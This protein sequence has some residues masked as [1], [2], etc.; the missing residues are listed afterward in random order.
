VTDEYTADVRGAYSA[1]AAAWAAGP[2]AHYRR[3][4]TALVAPAGDALR[5]AAVLD[6]G[7]GTGVVAD[8]AVA[9]GAS[10]VIGVDA[11]VAMLRHDAHRRPVAVASDTLALPFAGGSFDVA[12]AGCVLNHLFEPAAGVAEMIRV[13]RPGGKVLAS[14]FGD[15]AEHPAKAA[16]DGSLV[17]FGF[18]IPQWHDVL[19]EHIEPLTATEQGLFSTANGPRV[20]SARVE[21]VEVDSGLH[22][23]DDFVRWR[24]GMASVAPFYDALAPAEQ[25]RAYEAACAAVGPSPPPY[26]TT[27]LVLVVEVAEA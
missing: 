15:E 22:T 13:T 26:I 5:G 24:V 23:P 21:R 14:T 6:V 20:G 10:K 2:A 1:S 16:I 25:K 9:A 19:K 11:A 18:H 3:L 4:A 8:A 12:A 17:A 7:T 27:L